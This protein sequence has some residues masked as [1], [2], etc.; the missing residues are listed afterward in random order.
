MVIKSIRELNHAVPFVPYE[1]HMASG[2]TYE[3]PH[4]DL[5]L[6]LREIRI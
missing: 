6:F 3:V 5:F 2:E 4:P 1:V